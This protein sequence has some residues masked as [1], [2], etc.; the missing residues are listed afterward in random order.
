MNKKQKQKTR[1]KSKLIL[2]ASVFIGF[3]SFSQTLDLETCLKM[4]DTANLSLKNARLDIASNQNQIS[5]Y[6]ASLLPKVNFNGDY[7]YYPVIP[8]NLFPAEFSGGK[9]GTYTV[10]QFGVPY[11]FSNT[12]QL[13]QTIYNPLLSSGLNSLKVNQKIVELQS[14]L[15]S[16]N[17][18]YQVYQTFFNLQAISKQLAFVESNLKNTDKLIANV[19]AFISQ[20]MML[21]V[22]ADKLNVNRLNLVN[23]QQ[24]LNSTKDQLEYLLK[25]LIGMDASEKIELVA[26]G[27]IEK[28]ILIDKAE[29]QNTELDIIN[30]QKELNQLEKSGLK[31][32]YLPTFSF[33]AA[34]NYGYNMRPETNFSKGINS[35]FI[36]VR[37]DWTLFDGFEKYNKAKV[38]RIQSEKL[39]NQL[40]LMDQQLAMTSEN[41]KKQVEIQMN[42]LIIAKE[43]LI[44]SEKIYNQVEAS[45]K[46]G[47]VSSND[48]IKAENDLNQSQT[49][50]ISSYVQLRQAELDLLK[51][52]GNLK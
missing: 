36:G 10:V 52:T 51:S 2:L 48:I 6:K 13:N 16:Q 44:L 12:I 28:S 23:Q 3:Q 19:N 27:L 31:M 43:Q 40:E 20:K 32:A 41:A 9:P 8:G 24:K 29:R 18:Q 17:T 39:N 42:S 35:S 15:T 7:R 21:S 38:N 47:I 1:I 4:A 30:A 33:Y 25:I 26:E 22:E 5:A 46:E 45:F 50:V 37:I 11:N 34:Y 14:K 49:N